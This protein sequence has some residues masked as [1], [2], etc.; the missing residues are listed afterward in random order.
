M[1][2]TTG[3]HYSFDFLYVKGPLFEIVWLIFS[4]STF[5]LYISLSF[6]RTPCWQ[7]TWCLVKRKRQTSHPLNEMLRQDDAKSRCMSWH[8][9]QTTRGRRPRRISRVLSSTYIYSFH[10]PHLN[11]NIPVPI[12]YIYIN[13][14]PD[15]WVC[16]CVFV[17]NKHVRKYAE[18]CFHHI[19]V[20]FMV[21]NI[22]IYYLII[23][24]VKQNYNINSKSPRR[25]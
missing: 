4:Y 10:F 13:L 25:V 3:Q 23:K 22:C 17:A 6:F 20:E 8:S 24:K 1:W 21:N 19:S 2:I 16:E 18:L 12:L 7:T 5:Y 9:F 11:I 14:N 15:M